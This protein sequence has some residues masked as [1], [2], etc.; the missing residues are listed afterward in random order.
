MPRLC[1]SRGGQLLK[2]ICV[3]RTD[4][5]TVWLNVYLSVTAVKFIRVF[6]SSKVSRYS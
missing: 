6:Q 2:T 3:A 5:D 1:G 4:Q